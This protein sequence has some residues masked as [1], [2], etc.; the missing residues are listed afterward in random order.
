MAICF[1][2]QS[3]HSLEKVIGLI[4]MEGAMEERVGVTEE[5][6]GRRV[7]NSK[8][9]EIAKGCMGEGVTLEV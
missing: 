8:R 3:N 1:G 4:Q 9:R 6:T 5:T 2:W 7:W